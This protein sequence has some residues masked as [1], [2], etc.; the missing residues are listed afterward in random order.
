MFSLMLVRRTALASWRATM[1]GFALAAVM[2]ALPLSACAST[3][4]SGTSQGAI[5]AAI[6]AATGAGLA[7]ATGR[8]PLAGAVVG[9]VAGAGAGV[10]IS[11]VDRSRP[12]EGDIREGVCTRREVSP[13]SSVA[14]IAGASWADLDGDGCV[15]GYLQNGR[16][17]PGRARVLASRTA[18]RQNRYA[19]RGT[20]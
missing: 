19:Q 7:V 20:H 15:D 17:L 14:G 16:I 18:Y 11:E 3:N 2:A 9:A 1:K 10:L 13:G 5:G 12:I 4:A 8:S 6:G